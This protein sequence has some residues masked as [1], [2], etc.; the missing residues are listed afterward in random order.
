[1]ERLHHMT[2]QDAA[3]NDEGAVLGGDEVRAAVVAEEVAAGVMLMPTLI[4]LSKPT[5]W[6]LDVSKS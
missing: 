2:L 4:G 3:Q 6:S 5:S 1:M